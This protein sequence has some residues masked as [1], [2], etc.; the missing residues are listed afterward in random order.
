MVLNVEVQSAME[1]IV[2]TWRVA[3]I[4]YI[5]RLGIKAI[6]WHCGEKGRNVDGGYDLPS[7]PVRGCL[8][9]LN[10]LP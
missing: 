7:I 10:F 6:P 3:L 9:V 2:N 5:Q 8:G 1:P 4:P